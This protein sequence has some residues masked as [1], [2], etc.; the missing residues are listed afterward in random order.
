ML[1][2]NAAGAVMPSLAA[3]RLATFGLR[4]IE[5]Q[6]ATMTR[7]MSAAVSPEAASAFSAAAAA[8][9]ATVSLSAMR[10]LDDADPVAD[11]LVVGVD[12]L[13]EVVV[14]DHPGR[15]VVPEREDLGRRGHGASDAGERLAGRPGRRGGEP[16]GER[17]RVR[18]DVDGPAG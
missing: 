7:S 1:R 8:M 13:G 3:T 16:L 12:H 11:P 4:S 15:L 6:V 18:G 9:S 17:R 10:R 14:G 5:E 2:S